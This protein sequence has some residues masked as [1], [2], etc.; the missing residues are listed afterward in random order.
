MGDWKLVLNGNRNDM[1]DGDGAFAVAAKGKKGKQ[2]QTQ[3]KEAVE[4]FKLAQDLSE[5]TNLAA[6]NPAK[7][8]ELRARYDAFAREAVPPKS[9]PAPAGFKSPKVWGEA[10]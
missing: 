8:A 7:V 9:A 4:L 1:D 6:Q 3:A 2:K 5:K 10:N